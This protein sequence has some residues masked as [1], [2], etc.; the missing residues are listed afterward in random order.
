[1]HRLVCLLV[2][3]AACGGS[4]FETGAAE[5]TGSTPPIMSAGATSFTG[6][7]ASGT[8]VKGWTID[9]FGEGAGADCQSQDVQPIGS[10]AIYTSQPD[11]TSGKKA[12]LATGD[13]VIVAESPPM[14]NGNAAAS[15]GVKGINGIVGIIT[16]SSFHLRADL[17]AD[18]IE[19][20]IN[21]GGTDGNGT[22]LSLTGP[23]TAPVCE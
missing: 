10:V 22:A 19:G 1:M 3:V 20:T 13:I 23:F 16:I 17:T 7:D 15:M 21:A 8:M 11:D 5:I 12:M 2:V 14:V 4:G 18:K 9:L 6:A